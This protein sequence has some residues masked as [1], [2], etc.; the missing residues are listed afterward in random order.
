[1]NCIDQVCPDYPRRC[2]M[3]ESYTSV[4]R[5]K[6]SFLTWAKPPCCGR[7]SGYHVECGPGATKGWTPL[8]WI[9]REKE[10]PLKA[11][12]VAFLAA[13]SPISDAETNKVTLSVDLEGS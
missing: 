13:R 9:Q 6:I 8:A 11:P 3:L 4:H 2:L 5:C 10:S 12:R 1:M 7:E